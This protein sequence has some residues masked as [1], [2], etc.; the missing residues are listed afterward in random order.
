MKLLISLALVA[1]VA[2]ECPN[3]CSGHGT[4][5]SQDA[6][7]CYQNYQGNDCSER[8]CYFGIAHVDTPKGDLNADGLVSGPL[9]TVVT[10]S[11]VYPWGTTEQYPNA[12]PN[13]GHFYME[14]SNKGICDRKSGQCDCFDGYSGT[15]CARAACPND[16]SGH[17]TC[18]SIKE[19][20]EMRSYDTNAHHTVTEVVAGKALDTSS[21]GCTTAP[22]CTVSDYSE[23][24][25]E[26]YSYDLWDQDK[27]MGC[28]C[29]PVYY[30]ADCSLK[31]CKYGVDPL[32]Y[33]NSDGV[34][35]QTTV[36]HLG[37]SGSN[38]AGT[39]TG[40]TNTDCTAHGT[41]VI[42][43][44]C[45]AQACTG[46]VGDGCTAGAKCKWAANAI[47]GTYKI[48]FYDVF[49][50]RYVTKPITTAATSAKIKEALEAL[51]NG[52]I[53]ATNTDETAVN[54]AAV[55][56]T[57]QATNCAESSTAGTST[58]G[59]IGQGVEGDNGVGFGT[60][61]DTGTEYTVTFKTNPGVLR[62]IELDTQQINVITGT[63]DF[64]VANARQGQFTSRYTVSGG[65]IQ[66]L[67]YG[68]KLMYH[69][70]PTSVTTDNAA[71]T[72]VKVGGQ[73]LIVTAVDAYKITLNE[74]YLGASISPKQ[75][76]TGITGGA[77][78]SGSPDVIYT[79]TASVTAIRALT[80]NAAG[81]GLIF[82]SCP[83]TGAGTVAASA[84]SINLVGNA[85]AGHDCELGTLLGACTGGTNTDCTAHGTSARAT[86]IGQTCTGDISDGCS[87]DG[88]A[89]V[90]TWTASN[91]LPLYRRTD[92]TDNQ[93]W[94]RP[95][96]S[97]GDTGALGTRAVQLTRGSPNI[98]HTQAHASTATVTS[99]VA[100]TKTLTVSGANGAQ[101]TTV[102]V[103]VNGFGPLNAA[104]AVVTAADTSYVV[105]DATAGVFAA[106]F[107]SATFPYSIVKDSED[108]SIVAGSVLI[109]GGRRYRVASR[110]SGTSGKIVLTEN[111]A[112][113]Q[114]Q[115]LCTACVTKA[116]AATM[117]VTSAPNRFSGITTGDLLAISGYANLE[118]AVTYTRASAYSGTT[119][120]VAGAAKGTFATAA[121]VNSEEFRCTGGTNTDC[122][123][124]TAGQTACEAQACTGGTANGCSAGGKCV[125]VA[126]LNLYKLGGQNYGLYG[127]CAGGTNT[128]CTAHGNVIE[129]TCTAQ[130]CTGGTANGCTAT[131]KC[132]WTQ[133]GNMPIIVTEKKDNAGYQYVAQCSN[134]GTCDAATGLCKCFK[135][136]SRDNCNTQ[137]MLAV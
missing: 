102:D 93:N 73:E 40:G 60:K 28:K 35:R 64:W 97:T 103:F 124:I 78:E 70:N 25:Q 65:R 21:T 61:Y 119:V 14:C 44:T 16:C 134:R 62:S 84:A 106:D 126:N 41:S 4:C 132:V 75:I 80:I 74:P 52:V 101:A 39:C 47:T 108:T 113:G 100:S 24:V 88:S 34:I 86:C 20:A 38:M 18:E 125:H 136:Y 89:G 36:V 67:Q 127:S 131:N 109:L 10:G 9:T 112:G 135:G 105:S 90:C 121:G 11:E 76:D 110:A 83:V 116:V 33:D 63:P 133:I 128:D 96:A 129:A 2:A 58:V 137:N 6:C 50:E 27:T 54:P 82:N 123:A 71:N 43:A 23:L 26:S 68:S 118:N 69:N 31:K 57:K 37:S 117:T 115:K 66:M 120:A 122:T 15:A 53:A 49:G 8:T 5:G 72:L 81:T 94:Y 87:A 30:G 107:A 55:T 59:G 17:G 114:V 85:G 42:R 29:D 77:I 104:T 32:F 12:N 48:V 45:V 13:E 111:F 98:Y 79:A 3:A 7:S 99:Y 22:H 92:E 56:V 130:A 51:P 19:L 95:T 1:F 46:G 91:Q